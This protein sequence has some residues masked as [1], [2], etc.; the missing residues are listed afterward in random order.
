[1]ISM[2]AIMRSG[3]HILRMFPLLLLPLQL[4]GH[5]RRAANAFEHQLLQSGLSPYIA[6]ELA[7]AYEKANEDLMKTFRSLSTWT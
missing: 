5:K 2:T 3:Y 6:R 1:M 7:R 4:K